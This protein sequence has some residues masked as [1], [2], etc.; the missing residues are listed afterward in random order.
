MLLG[1]FFGVFVSFFMFHR[2]LNLVREEIR[3]RGYSRRTEQVYLALLKEF[4]FFLA[5]CDRAGVVLD[6]VVY[7]QALARGE[8]V[9]L[10]IDEVKIRAF[11]MEKVERDLSS[12]TV[13]LYLCAIK[14]FY[15]RTLRCRGA[16]EIVF[17]RRN[18]RLPV[19]LSRRE[20]VLLIRNVKNL[21]HRLMVALAY[22]S[23]LRV[24]ELVHLKVRDLDFDGRRILVREGK[25][26][27]D[28]LTVLPDKLF[29]QLQR[30]CFGKSG[31][32]FVFESERGGRL[33]ER[34]L[35]TVFHRARKKAGILKDAHFHSLRH[36]FATHLLENGTNIRFV[37]ELLGHRDI[38][39]TQ[40][41]TQVSEGVLGRVKSPL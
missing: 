28:R 27:K 30:C 7:D 19:V 40:I 24:G 14:F 29:V 4:F 41:Y 1:Y 23:G 35:Q 25:G 38:K 39:T 17:A 15:F 2:L 31:G 16:L 21:K 3:L 20:V 6:R 36:S 8:S 9:F 18:R 32:D 10:E 33:H 22:G 5:G 37:Q 12:E 26:K 11:L 34:S 13:N